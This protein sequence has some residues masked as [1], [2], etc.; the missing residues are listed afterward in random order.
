ML[1]RSTLVATF[2][3]TVMLGNAAIAAPGDIILVSSSDD[4]VEGNSDSTRSDVSADGR[5]VAFDSKAT[6][7]DPLDTD[8]FEDIYVKDLATGGIV[9]ASVAPGKSKGN[10]KGKG[11]GGSP[12][13]GN[14][15][16]LRPSLSGDG[17]LVAF[18]TGSSNLH[19]DDPFGGLDIYVKNLLTGE[20]ILASR[21]ADG[22]KG[23]GPS[24]RASISDDGTKVAFQSAATNLD[25]LDTETTYD[26]YVKD[27]VTGSVD[28]V[29]VTA[30]GVKGN[31]V[32]FTPTISPNGTRVAFSSQ[33]TNLHPA[34]TDTVADLYVKDLV[35]GELFLASSSDEGVSGNGS[36]FGASL[37]EDGSVVAFTSQASNL[38]PADPDAWEDAYVKDLRT[39]DLILVSAASDGTK[40]D[41]L[42]GS[43]SI[44]ADGRL[45]AFESL[46]T[47]LH[48][49]DQDG[50]D[51]VFLKDLVT[52]EISLLS[53]TAAGE[54]GTGHSG[55]VS[56]SA[57]AAIVAFSSTASNLHP[58]M[59]G[60]TQVLAKER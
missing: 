59:T 53:V 12:T 30:A 10:G 34:D 25:A 36:S 60:R 2:A 21:A 3:V 26:V 1:V 50:F 43:G 24:A 41:G 14:L 22:T 23:N 31:G 27:L 47:N 45:V 6:N 19:P 58:D 39:G 28:L 42:S 33:S 32:S 13:K 16:S 20:L 57:D 37:S 7:L 15:Y 35:T 4:G 48:P 40:G 56:A 29:S 44:T 38:D 9:L 46:S 5:F 51:D 18:D 49:A 8:S 17:S 52:G 54:K 11:G 55:G